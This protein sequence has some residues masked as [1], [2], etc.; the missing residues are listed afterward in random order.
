MSEPLTPEALVEMMK[1]SPM[2]PVWGIEQ[3]T[4]NRMGYQDH[5]A[6]L[7]L[8]ADLLDVIYT[9]RGVLSDD[10]WSCDPRDVASGASSPFDTPAWRSVATSLRKGST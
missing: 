6:L 10:N 9:M 1:R 3:G 2:T 8:V 4:L 5:P 7:R